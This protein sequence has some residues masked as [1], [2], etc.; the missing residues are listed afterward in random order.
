[1]KLTKQQEDEILKRIQMI[2][3]ELEKQ[4]NTIEFIQDNF[5]QLNFIK[6]NDK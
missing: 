2:E 5:R 6:E 3:A 1:M 4:S